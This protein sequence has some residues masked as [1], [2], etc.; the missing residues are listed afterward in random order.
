MKKILLSVLAVLSIATINAQI[1]TA[2]DAATF[3]TW[4]VLD[5][6]ADTYTW[7]LYDV[8]PVA[9]LAAQGEA[10]V[11]FSWGDPGQGAGNES[12]LTP[13]NWIVSPIMDFSTMTAASLSFT[14]A[15]LEAAGSIYAAEHWAV[16]AATSPA[17]LAT[18]TALIEEDVLD[19]GTVYAKIA[20]LDAF[21]G[22]AIVYIAF[23]HF[24]VTDMYGLVLDDVVVTGTTSGAGINEN[25][26]S[27]SVFPNPAT[28]VLNIKLT[29]NATSVS[30]LGMDGKVISTESVNSNVVA[31]NVSNLVSGVYFYEVVAENGTVIRNTFV[32]K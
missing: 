18:A 3:A 19:G 23:R 24:N 1:L 25:T 5:V 32:K 29:E 12:A 16:Y 4:S 28:D 15:S 30:I 17:G 6:D 20:N 14:V 13:D 9:H 27:A 8:A 22:E 26:I 10:A 7:G 21:A 31:V 2:N 11:S